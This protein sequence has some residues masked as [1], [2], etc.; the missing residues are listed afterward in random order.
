MLIILF[1]T[2]IGFKCVRI[3]SFSLSVLFDD[4]LFW[5]RDILWFTQRRPV[6]NTSLW[7]S[8][9]GLGVGTV[10]PEIWHVCV[11]S[12]KLD[13]HFVNLF[14]SIFL[15]TRF[16]ILERLLLVL[17][18]STLTKKSWI[19]SFW[20]VLDCS[21]GTLERLTI[22]K[23]TKDCSDVSLHLFSSTVWSWDEP[24]WTAV[25]LPAH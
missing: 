16:H 11:L 4:W 20:N 6:V 12:R 14:Q 24:Y 5:K 21:V 13:V 22:G 23:Q 17:L 19:F 9:E 8:L 25:F 15:K 1:A 18:P 10:P 7:S 3:F 2:I